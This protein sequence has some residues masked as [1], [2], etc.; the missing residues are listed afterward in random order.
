MFRLF[1]LQ[2]SVHLFHTG[3]YPIEKGATRSHVYVMSSKNLSISR[4]NIFVKEDYFLF[5]V[6][7]I[8]SYTIILT[9]PHPSSKVYYRLF[10]GLCELGGGAIYLFIWNS[11]MGLI[12]MK[13]G[14]RKEI[15]YYSIICHFNHIF[16]STLTIYFPPSTLSFTP[17]ST[18]TLPF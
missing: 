9:T 14:T 3:G 8:D 10:I 15:V 7:Q 13:T 4:R 5:K 6:P 12:N 1:R 17:P 2:C 16:H 11:T 18:L